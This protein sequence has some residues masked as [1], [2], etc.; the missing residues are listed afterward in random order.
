MTPRL[1]RIT[2][3]SLAALWGLSPDTLHAVDGVVEI[4]QTTASEGDATIGDDTPGLPVI[5]AVPGSYRLTGDLTTADVNTDLVVI[6]ADNVT[7]DL[8]GFALRGPTTCTGSPQV[9]CSPSGLGRGVYST[10]GRT[11]ILNGSVVGMPH[12][13]LCVLQSRIERVRAEHNGDD[14]INTATG[15]SIIDCRAVSNGGDGIQGGGLLS[16]IAANDNAGY[17]LNLSINS[18]YSS[19][20]VNDNDSGTISGGTELGQNVCNG[21]TT[22]P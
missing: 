22:C 9:T 7:L 17:G 3:V 16:Q 19:V 5:I 11:T 20:V 12:H 4:N 6:T 18:A 2:L 14:G 13:G 1:M 15:S 10:G 21:N 8:N